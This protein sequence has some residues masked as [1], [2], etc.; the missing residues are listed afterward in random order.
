MGI[1][2]DVEEQAI[3][4]NMASPMRIPSRV[5]SPHDR[6]CGISCAPGAPEKLFLWGHNSLLQL[7]WAKDEDGKSESKPVWRSYKD[8]N[9]EMRN[10]L[11]MSLLD[12]GEWGAPLLE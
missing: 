4:A 1:V 10:I 5:L 3:A 11:A 6:I 7:S 9:Q 8:G 12:E 2:F